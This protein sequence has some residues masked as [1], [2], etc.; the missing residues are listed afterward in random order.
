MQNSNN[1]QISLFS[2]LPVDIVEDIYYLAD[3][4]AELKKYFQRNVLTM[5]DPTLCFLSSDSCDSCFLHDCKIRISGKIEPFHKKVC[6][7]CRKVRNGDVMVSA[8]SA[9]Q[10]WRAQYGV[11]ALCG[12]EQWKQTILT[13]SHG[14]NERRGPWYSID[15]QHPVMTAVLVYRSALVKRR[16]DEEVLKVARSAMKLGF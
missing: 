1:A 2:L 8:H 6:F 5:V 3:K 9:S 13:W 15:E 10:Q 7:A 16:S 4:K 11:L 14:S 12:A